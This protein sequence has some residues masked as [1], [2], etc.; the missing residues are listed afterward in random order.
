MSQA[1]G[2]SGE[3]PPTAVDIIEAIEAMVA[4]SRRVPFTG[5]VVVNDEELLGLLERLRLSLPDELVRAHQL[6]DERERVLSQTEEESGRLRERAEAAAR[7]LAERTEASAQ[8]VAE[9]AREEAV[10]LRKRV[11]AEA[12]QV[13]EEARARAE[14]MVAEHTVL[15]AAEDRAAGIVR[16]A[17]ATAERV[18]GEAQD[19]VRQAE[20]YVRLLMTELEE[21]LAKAT[22]T[23]RNGL[24]AIQRDAHPETGEQPAAGRRR[25]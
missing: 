11:E 8:R 4:E 12:R 20:D 17:Q 18:T 2:S 3:A 14:Q 16:D 25:R 7:S 9:H 15:R 10:Q 21:Q 24:R 13:I 6:L 19:Y 5:T 22:A 23:V 1:T